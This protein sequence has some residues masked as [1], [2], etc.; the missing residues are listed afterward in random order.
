[1][2]DAMAN[3]ADMVAMP[4]IGDSG[5]VFCPAVQLNIARP[6]LYNSSMSHVF[7]YLRCDLTFFR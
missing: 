1:M 5:N 7:I 4:R 6:Q 3:M 2:R